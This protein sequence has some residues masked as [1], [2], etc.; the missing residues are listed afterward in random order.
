[1]LRA[2]P[3]LP[4]AQCAPVVA[5]A[6]R[7]LGPR[8][9]PFAVDSAGAVHNSLLRAAA[10]D[11]EVGRVLEHLVT[12]PMLP[13]A[14]GVARDVATAP[15][16]AA[17]YALAIP[18]YTHFTSPIRRYADVMVHRLL[19]LAVRAQAAAAGVPAPRQLP[20]PPPVATAERAPE[21][22]PAPAPPPLPL[23]QLPA[24][25]VDA[26]AAQ[27]EVCNERKL[28]ARKAQDASDLVYLAVLLARGGP[29]PADALVVEAAGDKSLTL[30]V[31]GLGL[32]RR[33]F[34]DRCGLVADADAGGDGVRVRRATAQELLALGAR[35]GAADARLAPPAAGGAAG[36]AGGGAIN[37]GGDSGGG[38]FASD[39]M[40]PPPPPPLPLLPLAASLAARGVA[41]Q[42]AAGVD[43]F[44]DAHDGTLWLRPMSKFRVNLVAR[45]GRVPIEVDVELVA[46]L[47]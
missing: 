17:H 19:A 34:Y 11:A 30:L 14:Y 3:P 32:E 43:L 4:A 39:G 6:A 47:R 16:G 10:A 27:C 44:R 24:S 21:P 29:L 33:V 5:L 9:P 36:G 2:H 15:G 41:A 13:A 1:V 40:T 22:A 18:V 46:H 42:V 45:M 28:C 23:V 7:L 26:L 8:A 25:D 38:S 37:G 20:P 31:D 12:K 35:G